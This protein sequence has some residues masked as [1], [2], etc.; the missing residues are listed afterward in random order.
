MLQKK[1]EE[2]I[3]KNFPN[4]PRLQLADLRILGDPKQEK[5][6]EIH[7]QMHCNQTAE[8]QRKNFASSQRKPTHST[9]NNNDSNDYGFLIRNYGHQKAVQLHFQSIARK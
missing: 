3:A 2:T 5:L 8:T 1:F 4:I 7:I 6:N 9:Q